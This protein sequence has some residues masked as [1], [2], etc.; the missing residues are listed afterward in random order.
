M[1]EGSDEEDRPDKTLANTFEETKGAFRLSTFNGLHLENSI[2][3][4]GTVSGRV[5]LPKRLPSH[6]RRC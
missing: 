3:M 5:S 2:I 4:M 1:P 6:W